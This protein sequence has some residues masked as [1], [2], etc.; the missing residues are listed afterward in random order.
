MFQQSRQHS[1]LATCAKWRGTGGLGHWRKS[2]WD[3]AH[4]IP[5]KWCLEHDCCKYSLSCLVH[6]DNKDVSAKPTTQPPGHMREVARDRRARVLE[7]ER[8]V[9]KAN[10]PVERYG[11]VD[12]Q[13]KKV[14]VVGLQSVV[15]KNQVDA[16]VSQIDVMQRMKDMYVKIMGHKKY[17]EKIVALMNQMPRMDWSANHSVSAMQSVRIMTVVTLQ[18]SYLIG[19]G[20]WR[21]GNCIPAT[22][23]LWSFKL[24]K[25]F[26]LL[27]STLN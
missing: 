11:D 26:P 23:Y 12:H 15:K 17:D 18:P 24:L 4:H 2:A 14:K 25:S 21:G 8:V 9:Q 27:R 16:I 5:P 3:V 13:M 1:P 10:W 7:E 20:S 19:L 22:Q 6:K